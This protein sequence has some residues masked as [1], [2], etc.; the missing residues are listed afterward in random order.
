M[1]SIKL[2]PDRFGIWIFVFFLF[3]TLSLSNPFT[4]MA[5]NHGD[6]VRVQ[7]G[8]T[9]YLIQNGQ[10][11]AF[12]NEEIFGRMGYKLKDVKTLAPQTLMSIPEG[13]SIWS[14]ETVGALA[15]G[16]LIRLQGQTHTYVI[17]GGKKC[18]IP[19]PET[20]QSRGYQWS[21]VMD[22]DKATLD[23][24]ATGIPIPSVKPPYQ[25]TPP[26]KV[27][28][29]PTPGAPVTASPS[30]YPSA[31]PASGSPPYPS[32]STSYRSM[33]SPPSTYPSTSQPMTSYP[34]SSYPPSGYPSSSSPSYP[35]TGSYP[36][37]SYPSSSSGYPSSSVFPDGTLVK[38][39]GP[40]IYLIQ[41]GRRCLIPDLKTLNNLG[42]NQSNIVT[43]DDST[44]KSIP[45]GNP[46]PK[47]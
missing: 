5:Q 35:S 30:P 36:S 38:G 47:K 26:G 44:L 21:Q 24:I 4:I 15:E 31:P 20:F 42:L 25:Y 19:D 41:N 9:I 33:S 45:L 2:S 17:Q 43:I 34:P 14:R 32:P 28:G 11:R 8:T 22:V 46:I 10:R 27:S 40:Q 13:P 7:G 1:N 37:S 16:T 3:A 39:P 18:Y 12:A 6:V 23:R 29:T